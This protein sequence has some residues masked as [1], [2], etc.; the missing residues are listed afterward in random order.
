MAKEIDPQSGQGKQ[1][2]DET[3]HPAGTEPPAG[4]AGVGASGQ[5][6][7]TPAAMQTHFTGS[8]GQLAVMA[9]FLHRCINVAVPLVDAGDDVFVVRHD[10]ESVIRVQVK[11]ANGVGNDQAYTAQFSLPL[12]QLQRVEPPALVYVFAVRHLGRWLDFIVIRRTTLQQIR[13]DFGIGSRYVKAGKEYLNLTL[14]F[15]QGNVTNKEASFQQY[16]N[17]WEPWPPSQPQPGVEGICP[18]LPGA[19]IPAPQGDAGHPAA[20]E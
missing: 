10:E 18:R 3:L 8:S 11:T 1:P 13:S 2:P 5:Q 9:E 6:A 20:D 15:T 14:S 12:A 19:T 17:V 16:R 7:A 4:G